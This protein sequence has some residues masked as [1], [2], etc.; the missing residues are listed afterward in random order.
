MEIG[1]TI[2]EHSELQAFL[3][4][5]NKFTKF[6][7]VLVKQSFVLLAIFFSAFLNPSFEA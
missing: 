3:I 5:D 2:T 1:G 6:L 7:L 4:G